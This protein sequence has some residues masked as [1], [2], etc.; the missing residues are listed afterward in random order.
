MSV[1]LLDAYCCAGGAAVGYARASFDVIGVDIEP[2]PEYPFP[3]VQGDAVEY[4][5]EHGHRFDRIH[6]SPPC[7]A[8]SGPTRGTN[9]RRRAHLHVDLIPDTRDALAST[10]RPYVIENVQG[11][12]L[13]RDV[14]LCGEMF[15]LAVIRH[16]YFEL[17]GWSTSPPS[18]VPHRGRVRG[19]RHG[20]YHDGPYLAVYGKGGGKAT[21]EECRIGL[22]IVHITDRAK[23]IEAIPPAYTEWLGRRWL[24]AS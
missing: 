12:A 14:V 17:G 16:R 9:R 22:G 13:R 24:A 19:W 6:A 8:S 5:G 1:R 23:L 3:F 10:G 18:H 15:G 4:I 2:Q 20:Q 21:T 7:Q 11:S